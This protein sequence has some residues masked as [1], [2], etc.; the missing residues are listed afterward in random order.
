M[1]N[2]VFRIEF[3]ENEDRKSLQTSTNVQNDRL[4]SINCNH[5]HNHYHTNGGQSIINV[6][7]KSLPI[8]I[9][10][11]NNHKR[12]VNEHRPMVCHRTMAHSSPML[13]T[14]NGKKHRNHLNY[15]RSHLDNEFDNQDEETFQEDENDNHND[16]NYLRENDA[17]YHRGGNGGQ[18]NTPIHNGNNNFLNTIDPNLLTFKA[19]M[20]QLLIAFGF[21]MIGVI[22]NL[23]IIA[24]IHE[25]VPFEQPPL[26]DVSFDLLPKRDSAL[27]ISEY[28]IMFMSS[29]LMV[30]ILFHRFRWIVMLRLFIILGILYTLRAICMAVTQMPVSN[31]QYHCSP[32]M[33]IDQRPVDFWPLIKIFISR[34]AYMSVGMG[35]SVNG[36][37]TYCGDFIFSGHT[38]ILV[39]CKLF[40]HVLLCAISL[41]F[42]FLLGNLFLTYYWLSNDRRLLFLLLKY[43]YHLLVFLGIV[44]ILVARGHYFVDIILAYIISKLIF[45]FYHIMVHYCI[46]EKEQMSYNGG[47][48]NHP[49][50]NNYHHYYHNRNYTHHCQSYLNG[51]GIIDANRNHHIHMPNQMIDDIIIGQCQYNRR[52]PLNTWWQ[53]LFEYLERITIENRIIIINTFEWPW[54]MFKKQQNMLIMV[55]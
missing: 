16:D 2:D 20:P 46:I 52:N 45:H 39:I 41:K 50:V 35:L 17:M 38:V 11:A 44:A 12:N 37:H 30:M 22:F 28:I 55:I 19:T 9:L 27:Y 34:V 15:R 42:S 51:N 53:P 4:I 33:S 1:A 54:N 23:T 8:Q 26:P 7:N 10:T 48:E 49:F 14:N 25:R 21:L 3:D 18:E 5:L 24:I 32:R 13:M 36:H 47:T 31:P 29:S 43:V 6:N 40:I